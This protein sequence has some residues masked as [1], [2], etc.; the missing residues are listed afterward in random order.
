VAQAISID[1]DSRR[2]AFIREADA[3]GLE[4]QMTFPCVLSGRHHGSNLV[5]H[6]NGKVEVRRTGQQVLAQESWGRGGPA[7]DR[8]PGVHVARFDKNCGSSVR[9]CRHSPGRGAGFIE[10]F[11]FGLESRGEF[12]DEDAFSACLGGCDMSSYGLR[13]APVLSGNESTFFD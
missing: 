3:I 4:I 9:V 8:S 5:T 12:V 6:L 13:T 10:R 1:P 7:D 11:L 2:I